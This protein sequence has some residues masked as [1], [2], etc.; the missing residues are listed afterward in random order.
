MK[1]LW[2]ASDIVSQS[3]HRTH[4]CSRQEDPT[5]HSK[6]NIGLALFEQAHGT[7]CKCI[8]LHNLRQYA[9]NG[10]YTY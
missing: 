1:D 7:L 3:M 8:F 10:F 4:C 6:F 5:P 2:S 9:K